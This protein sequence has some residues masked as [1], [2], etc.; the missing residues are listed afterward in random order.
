MC[1]LSRA[2]TTVQVGHETRLKSLCL[3]G[4][5]ACAARIVRC[6]VIVDVNFSVS[7][8]FP[9]ENVISVRF[10]FT[11]LCFHTQNCLAFF[12]LCIFSKTGSVVQF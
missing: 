3:F 9:V 1:L 8:D 12:D 5:A 11:N 2:A 6:G 7:D 10:A 4:R